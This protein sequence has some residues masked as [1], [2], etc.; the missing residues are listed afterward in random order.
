MAKPSWL[1]EYCGAATA[2]ALAEH[3]P[4]P[5]T[6]KEQ[7]KANARCKTDN[8]RNAQAAFR[9]LRGD[10]ALGLVDVSTALGKSSG[11]GSE[12]GVQ[13]GACSRTGQAAAWM[14]MVRPGGKMPQS[15]SKLSQRCGF[16]KCLVKISA[17]WERV[18]TYRSLMPSL[19]QTSTNQSTDTR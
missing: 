16:V 19:R 1:S 8:R 10:L 5:E 12:T 7:A 13:A 18:F 17:S 9:L 15:E 6:A 4:W 2:A 3:V 14:G 11:M